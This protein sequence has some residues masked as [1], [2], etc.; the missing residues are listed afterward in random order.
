MV[1]SDIFT[2]PLPLSS[3]HCQKQVSAVRPTAPKTLGSSLFVY[4]PAKLRAQIDRSH[5]S[6]KNPTWINSIRHCTRSHTPPPNLTCSH[7]PSHTPRTIHYCVA[8][9]ALVTLAHIIPVT[10]A[11]VMSASIDFDRAVD[12]G[13]NFSKEISCSVFCVD[14]DLRLRF[15]IWGL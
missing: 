13:Q 10:S 11:L 12:R 7:V 3:A 1:F 15:L 8:A 14:S 6:K 5:N 9:S 2:L 4:H